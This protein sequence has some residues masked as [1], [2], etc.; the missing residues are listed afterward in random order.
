MRQREQQAL[1]QRI[2]AL[3]SQGVPN[4][5]IAKTLGCHRTTVDDHTRRARLLLRHGLQASAV[6]LYERHGLST[7]QVAALL[8]LK[9]RRVAGWV[10]AAGVSRPRLEAIWLR[11]QHAPG[12]H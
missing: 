8:G 2:L 3:W 6:Q 4:K 10:L 12:P 5:A 11:R 9:Q 1:K 7:Y